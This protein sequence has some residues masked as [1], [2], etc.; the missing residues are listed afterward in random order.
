MLDTTPWLSCDECFERMDTHVEAL[1]RD[2]GHHDL[3]MDR[4]LQGC[5]ACQE[6]V[7]S[8]RALLTSEGTARRGD[9][10]PEAGSADQPG[11]LTR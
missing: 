11:P 6:E 1:L 2:P 3:A 5:A 9:H 7:Q 10:G 8:L 4:H